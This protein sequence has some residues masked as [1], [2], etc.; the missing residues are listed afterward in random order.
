MNAAEL[1]DPATWEPTQKSMEHLRKCLTALE[2]IR[3]I[4]GSG[5]IAQ[6]AEDAMRNKAHNLG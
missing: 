4:A 2:K 5:P 3:G 1:R 6:I